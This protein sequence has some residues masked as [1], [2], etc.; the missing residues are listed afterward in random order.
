MSSKP[1]NVDVDALLEF[2][3]RLG[4]A[5]LACGE[6]TAKVELIL[7]RTASAYGVRR[8]RIVAFPTAIFISVHKGDDERVTLA[9]GPTQTL[10]LDQIAD[11]YTLGDAAQRGEV[12][13]AEGLAR[14]NEILR[15]PARFGVVGAFVGH[16]ILSVGVAMV[17]AP[18]P[19]NVAAAALLGAVVG[20]VKALQKDRP[21]L[22][23]PLPVVAAAIVSGLVFLAVRY[24][25]PVEPLHAMAPPLVTFLPGAMLTLGMVELAYGDMVS[26]SSRLITGL[27]QLVLLAFGLAAGALLVGYEPD[28]LSDA[29]RAVAAS[30]WSSWAPWAGVVV[31]GVGAYLHFS[32]PR[33]SLEWMLLVLLAAFAV[34]QAAAGVFGKAGSGFFGMLVATPLGY[35]I[36]LRFKGPPAMVTFLPSFWLLVPGALG[37]LSFQHMLSDREAGLDALMLAVFILASLALGTLMGAALYKW[38]TERFG[39]WQLQIGRVG[40]YLRLTRKR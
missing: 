23:A 17:L 27:V 10:R 19:T 24:D 7:R 13:P 33:K 35:L 25:W 1:A 15:T 32:A 4:Q 28:N 14:L 37:L 31:F 6:Q 40:S 16:I 30:P 2:M 39:W 22:A 26:G 34:Q 9:E 8:S 21:V 11:V 18:T 29:S 5:H 38:V 12:P 36:Q 20:A 3:F